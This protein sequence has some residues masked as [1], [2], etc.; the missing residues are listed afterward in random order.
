V[1]REGTELLTRLF[2]HDAWANAEVLAAL[3]RAGHAPERAWRLFFHVLAA[4]DL[5]LGRLAG[6]PPRLP[7]WPA[8]DPARAELL[9]LE[10][11]QRWRRRLGEADPEWLASSIEYHNS[12]GEPWTSGVR[13][14][15]LHVLEHSTYHRGQIALVLRDAGEEPPITDYVHAAR[16]GLLGP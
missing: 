1:A 14:V 3:G 12:K 4:E 2:R 5:W 8:L 11:E 13:D 7:V 10:L 9:A 16:H 6:E 15:L